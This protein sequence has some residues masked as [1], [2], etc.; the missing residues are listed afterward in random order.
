MAE[1]LSA[2]Q[3]MKATM[4]VNGL[5]PGARFYAAQLH[6]AVR[7]RQVQVRTGPPPCW[8]G[9]W[10]DCHQRSG[11]C[12][13]AGLKQIGAA[14]PLLVVA[15]AGSHAGIPRAAAAFVVHTGRLQACG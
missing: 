12:E 13:A 7:L 14:P 3:H 1:V 15:S 11:T 10:L 6:A 9:C 8:R 2:V 4:L 5:Q